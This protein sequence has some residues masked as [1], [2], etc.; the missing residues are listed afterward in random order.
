MSVPKDVRAG[1]PRSPGR[2]LARPPPGVNRRA[3]RGITT[4]D[5]LCRLAGILADAPLAA[6]SFRW[7]F[8]ALACVWRAA[9]H[10][11]ITDRPGPAMSPALRNAAKYGD[12]FL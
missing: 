11:G 3:P 2:I 9:R 5:A 1:C 8:F 10:P 7:Q 12:T 6:V 4:F